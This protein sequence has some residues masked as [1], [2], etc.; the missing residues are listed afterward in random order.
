MR[1]INASE[2]NYHLGKYKILG[3][4]C[5]IVGSLALVS[6]IA[7]AFTIGTVAVPIMIFASI[8][9]NSVGVMLVRYKGDNR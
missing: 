5:L 8:F 3:I 6:G 2:R 1:M 7:A 9:V 4:L